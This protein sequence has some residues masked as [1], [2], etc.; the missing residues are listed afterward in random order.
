M[1]ENIHALANVLPCFFRKTG[2]EGNR[3]TDAEPL[4]CIDDFVGSFNIQMLVDDR[5]HSL[6][7]DFDAVKNS[8]AT[9]LCHQFEKLFIHTVR[10]RTTGPSEAL[11]GSDHGIA[12][13]HH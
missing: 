9:G 5:L 12:E 8:T 1:Y 10:A 6:R 2:D 4:G 7:A 13:G 11:P 3:T